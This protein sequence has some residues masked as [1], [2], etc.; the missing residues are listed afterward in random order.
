MPVSQG[1][2]KLK[3]GVQNCFTFLL[4]SSVLYVSK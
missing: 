1:M 3:V 2:E 4:F